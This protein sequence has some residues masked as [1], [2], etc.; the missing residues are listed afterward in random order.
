MVTI[1]S[2]RFADLIQQD[3]RAIVLQQLDTEVE[4]NPCR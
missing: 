3:V 4:P 1:H 2:N